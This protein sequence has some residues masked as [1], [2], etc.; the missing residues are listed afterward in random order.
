MTAA[1]WKHLEFDW[2]WGIDTTRPDHAAGPA[3]TEEDNPVT[4]RILGPQG[5]LLVAVRAKRTVT[6][7]FGNG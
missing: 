2:E 4:G 1:R 3:L 6:F 5:Q 7:G